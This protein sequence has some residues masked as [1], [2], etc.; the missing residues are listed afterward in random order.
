MKNSK[1]KSQQKLKVFLKTVLKSLNDDKAEDIV[2]LDM[3]EQNHIADYVVIATCRS[4]RHVISTANKLADKLTGKGIVSNIGIEGAAKGD[5]VLVDAKYII[6][7]IF[8]KE[9]R[10][11][12]DIEKI[13][14]ITNT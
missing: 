9:V 7:H 3:N 10:V 11:L 12:Y 5:W 2:V 8:I 1:K 6:I 14:S 13:L 4:S